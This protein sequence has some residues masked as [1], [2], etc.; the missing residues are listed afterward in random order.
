MC[1]VVQTSRDSQHLVDTVL[2]YLVHE[3]LF[4]LLMNGSELLLK[5]AEVT[6][7]PS[8]GQFSNFCTTTPLHKD[9]I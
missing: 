1:V 7:E 9:G 8:A 6:V 4:D 2:T 5:K 3:N